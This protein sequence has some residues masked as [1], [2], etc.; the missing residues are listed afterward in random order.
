MVSLVEQMANYRTPY[1]TRRTC[2]RNQCNTH[3]EAPSNQS[4]IPHVTLFDN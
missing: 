4:N 2:Y 3:T 1:K